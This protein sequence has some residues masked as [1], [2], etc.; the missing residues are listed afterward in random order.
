MSSILYSQTNYYVSS[1]NGSDSNDGLSESSS[2]QTINKAISKVAAG[3]TVLVMNGVYQNN[4]YGTVDVNSYSNMN[5]EHVVTI[6][7]SGEV[8]A[9]ITLKNYPGHLP[10][11]KFDGKGGI[12]IS[13]NMNYII[14]EGFEVEG[15]A[16][17]I[18][19]SQAYA[20]R[21]YKVS[22]AEDNDDSTNYTH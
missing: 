20:N 12:V 8:G 2:F 7:K 1:I 17:N 15:P 14:V 5:N 13:N 4:G 9:Y 11:I 18:T 10:K 21:G 3:D 19:Y 16:A 6:N 22:L